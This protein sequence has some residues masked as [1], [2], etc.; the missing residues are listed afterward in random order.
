[1][2]LV[3][4]GASGFIGSALCP[5]LLEQGHTLTLFTRGS[6]RDASSGV[7]RWQLWTPGVLRDWDV[8]LDG[9]DGVINLAGEPIAEKK[10][11]QTQRRRL[12]KS[13]VDATQSLV[14]ACAKAKQKPKFLINASAIGYY[15]AR[16]DE[17]ITE[18]DPPGNDFLSQMCRDW[19]EEAKKAESLGMRVVRLRTGIVLGHGGGALRK[20]VEPFKYFL[21]GPI[22]SGKQWMSW[23][24]MEDQVRLILH[25]I[26][27]QQA[28]GP[29]NATAPNPVRNKEFS[30]ALGRVLHRPCWAP[31]PGFALRFGLG[32][33][34]EMLLTGQ[35]V[36]PA[37]AQ[38]LGFAFDFP[39]LPE[40]LQACMPL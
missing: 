19:E 31:V 37:A 24:H 35:R 25:V 40:A 4:T 2:R 33:M 27:N 6:P 8:E 9:A 23:I 32:D 38:R 26:D 17:E 30:Q 21:G 10:W 20:M 3:V 15:G 11:S 34:A 36:I 14:Q 16:A 5:R 1:M 12:V 18:A 13:R 22:G 28:S 7:K 39:N 29:I